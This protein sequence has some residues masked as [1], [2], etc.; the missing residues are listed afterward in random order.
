MLESG[1]IA[2]R[3]EYM[4]LLLSRLDVSKK[5]VM[6]S[7]PKAALVMAIGSKKVMA[8]GVPDFN[9]EWWVW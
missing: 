5:E 4:R 6:I 9:R 1:P 7:G 8:G 3:K 2:F